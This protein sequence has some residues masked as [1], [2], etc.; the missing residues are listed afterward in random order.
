M[1]KIHFYL[2]E[3]IW[4]EQALPQNYLYMITH[5]TQ[6]IWNGNGPQFFLTQR[7]LHLELQNFNWLGR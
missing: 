1:S 5:R 6:K 4:I 7:V 2:D 3:V